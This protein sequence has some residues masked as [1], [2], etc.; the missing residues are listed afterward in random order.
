MHPHYSLPLYQIQ[1]ARCSGASRAVPG[2]ALAFWKIGQPRRSGLRYGSP[3]RSMTQAVPRW[4]R[5]LGR[6]PATLVG[7]WVRLPVENY[8]WVSEGPN[9]SL[10]PGWREPCPEAGN[11]WGPGCVMDRF[12]RA[13]NFAA[14]Q[15]LSCV[16]HAHIGQALRARGPW[17][18]KQVTVAWTAPLIV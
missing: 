4:F 17:I 5:P 15:M 10:E 18:L 7:C 2:P 6:V 12:W 13:Q 9:E 16:R 11:H 8:S 3:K 14:G 1:C